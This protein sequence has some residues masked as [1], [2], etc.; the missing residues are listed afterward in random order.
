MDRAPTDKKTELLRVIRD[1]VWNLTSSPLYE[2]RKANNYYPV[3]GQGNH[4]TGIMFI[5]EGPGKNEAETGTPFCGAAGKLLDELLASI[6]LPR[7]DVYITNIIKDRPP[8]NRDPLPEEIKIYAPFLDRQIEI[9]QPKIIATLGRFSMAYIMER[10]GL[11]N[12]LKPIS[13]IHGKAFSINHPSGFPKIIIPLYHPAVAIY[14]RKQKETLLK[15]FQI[16][17]TLTRED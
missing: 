1:E 10:F 9:I 5:G 4:D 16:I 12:E 14:D 15:D 11:Q 6:N 3:I 17:N 8:Q 2:Y 7:K 13:V